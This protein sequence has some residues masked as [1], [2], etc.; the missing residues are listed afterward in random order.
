MAK[1][2]WLDINGVSHLWSKIKNHVSTNHYTKDEINDMLTAGVKYE[3]VTALPESDIKD[4]VIYLVSGASGDQNVHD[5]YMYINNQWE[6]IG[7]TAADISNFATKDELKAVSDKVDAIKTGLD[8]ATESI[9]LAPAFGAS[10][11]KTVTITAKDGTSVETVFKVTLPAEQV[12]DVPVKDVQVTAFD[13][14]TT[15]TA[16]DED[17]VVNFAA[18]TAAEIDAVCI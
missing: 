11:E 13:G 1:Y 18:I 17:G 6:K 14:T 8:T 9:E 5:E 4:G 16:V 2:A 12:V 15:A 10:D 3:V 7:T